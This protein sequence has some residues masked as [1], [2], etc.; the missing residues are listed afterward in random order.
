MDRNSI[1][2][3]L[4][5]AGILIGFSL[6]N[7]PS[8]EEIE[9]QK[10]EY[11]AQKLEL[12]KKDSLAALVN[13]DTLNTATDSAVVSND[14]TATQTNIVGTNPLADVE[15]D[16]TD[17][18][19]ASTLADPKDSVA[20][21]TV[22]DSLKNIALKKEQ[23][24]LAKANNKLK[25]GIF[26][27]SA[28]Q[29]PGEDISLEN[30][31]IRLTISPKGGYVA[32]AFIKGHQSYQD[33]AASL[34]SGIENTNK[35]IQ[36][37]DQDSSTQ[38]LELA[39]LNDGNFIK[40]KD[41]VF[42]PSSVSETQV[43]LRAAT[44]D[45]S[46][47]LEF[48]YTL[49]P[50]SYNVNYD[51]RFV[52]LD[53]EV[54][55]NHTILK[56]NMKGLLTE[57]SDYQE[58]RICGIFYKCLGEGRDYMGEMLDEKRASADLD[59]DMEWVAFKHNFFTSMV[60]SK[61]PF[62]K[63]GASLEA[64]NLLGSD[65]YSQQYIAELDISKELGSNTTIPLNFYFGPN[66][67]NELLAL[68]M[69]AEGIV[70]LGPSIFRTV[71]KWLIIPIFNMLK[72]TGWSYGVI[73]ILLTLIIKLIILPLTYRNYKSSAKMRILKPE[74]EKIAKKYPSREDA[75]KK[76]QET[77]SLYKQYGASPMAGCIPMLIQMPILFAAFRFFPSSM[78]LRQQSFLWAEDLSTYDQV[79]SWGGDIPFLS[80]A[81]GN[82]M[83]LFTIL[84]CISTLL[85]TRMNS[86]QMQ[87]Q[88]QPGMPN[89]Q[90]IMYFFPIMMLFFFN[91]FASGL[92]LYYLCGNVMNMGLMT[93]VKKYF[94]DE[95]K[96]RAQMNNKAKN[97]V[98]QSKF[99]QRL[100]Q[101]AKEQQ[102]KQ[103]NRK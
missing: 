41:L 92:C 70:N 85:Y 61:T 28:N 59:G 52:G 34:E 32:S 67:F 76:Q 30:D 50:E 77:M 53:T 98:K 79:F 57:K 36:L 13:V 71:N 14:T 103:R 80:W 72:S 94:V 81:Y 43:V 8:E 73:I 95:E 6:Y 93:A 46:K 4:L 16:S 84:M 60:Y 64:I 37:F 23:E 54:S 12:K 19:L 83:S 33:Y 97:P 20:Y 74:V 15:L 86:S 101:L 99:Q 75:M 25:Y 3:L 102:A 48:S 58:R 55:P 21:N 38:Y 89:M 62:K 11:E 96:I 63:D 90:V 100:A 10:K 68:N 18:V 24:I 49:A 56:W 66:D 45:P 26:A 78:D 69:E 22:I 35:E 91:S 47:Y 17:L 27:T 9:R 44:N 65:K 87:N 88:S 31:K 1:V 42:T 39:P 82:H 40:T 51:I 2:G 5:I 7:R 29:T